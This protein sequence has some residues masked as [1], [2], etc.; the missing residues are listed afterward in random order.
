MPDIIKVKSEDFEN[1]YELLAEFN[2]PRITKSDWQRLFVD[3]WNTGKD[4]FGYMICENNKVMGFLG[5]IFSQRNIKGN[6]YNFCNL[7]SWIVR[8]EYRSFSLTLLSK[9]VKEHKD[10]IITSLT[11]SS[12]VKTIYDRFKFIEIGRFS[13]IIAPMPY[14]SFNRNIKFEFSADLIM[15]SVDSSLQKIIHDHLQFDCFF[16]KITFKEQSCL[17][18][19][20]KVFKRGIPIIRIIYVSDKEMFRKNISRICMRLCIRHWALGMMIYDDL[21]SEEILKGKIYKKIEQSR[22]FLSTQGQIEQIDMLYS[23]IVILNV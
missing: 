20:N 15:G 23:E 7:T 14:F 21:I 22:S 10:Y 1:V 11:P 17:L 9:V 3:R 19:Y 18:I 6:N 5:L 12:D 4:Y 2:N 16:S 13:F 8:K